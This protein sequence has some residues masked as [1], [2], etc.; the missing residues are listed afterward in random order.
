MRTRSG[1][2]K[3][4]TQAAMSIVNISEM[5]VETFE[6]MMK[7]VAYLYYSDQGKKGPFCVC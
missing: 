2:T 4:S 3:S 1:K 6:G 7:L 5:K